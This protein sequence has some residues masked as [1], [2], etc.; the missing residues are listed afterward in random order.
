MTV[1]VLRRADLLALQGSKRN[2][3]PESL[4]PLASDVTDER[5]WVRFKGLPAEDVVFSLRGPGRVRSDVTDRYRLRSGEELMVDDLSL[6]PPASIFVSL[7]LRPD[8]EESLLLHDVEAVP[9]EGSEWPA[10]MSISVSADGVKRVELKDVPPGSWNVRALGRVQGGTLAV[11]GQRQVEV[12]GGIDQ[13]ITLEL[14]DL[15]FHGRVTRGGAAVT[16]NINLK[17][18]TAG[19]G[20]RTAVA[21]LDADGTFTVLLE[22]PG[23]YIAAVQETGANR[24]ARLGRPFHF[25]KPD[26]EVSIDLPEGRIS[27]RV[28]RDDGSPV[29]GAGIA[30][31]REDDSEEL[32]DA[33][34]AQSG[35]DGSF[36]LENIGEGTWSVR[37]SVAS[38]MSDD[39]AVR[40]AGGETTGVTLVVSPTRRVAIRVT[41]AIGHPAAGALVV[42]ELPAADPALPGEPLVRTS[43]GDGVVEVVTPQHLEKTPVNVYVIARDRTLSCATRRLDGDQTI[44]VPPAGAEVRLRRTRWA[45][46]PGVMPRLVSGQG[47]TVPMVGAH[48]ENRDGKADMVLPRLAAGAWSYVELRAPNDRALAATG[49]AALLPAIATWNTS[50]GNVTTIEIND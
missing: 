41:D 37:A 39:V 29:E 17:P 28:V 23:D 50:P 14:A 12:T 19:S 5:G 7:N 47:C 9:A 36:V 11:L 40:A 33:S 8:L 15:A 32:D 16:G 46:P 30:A 27:G 20:R 42:V 10:R 18:T 44:T 1:R 6:A 31:S 38:A 4:V 22:G 13:D 25:E 48:V 35:P 26:D 24:T 2:A 49:R 21:T 34:G 3:S 43:N 45:P